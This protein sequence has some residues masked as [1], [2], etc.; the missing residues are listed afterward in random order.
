MRLK[1]ILKKTEAENVTSFIFDIFDKDVQFVWKAG[2]FLHYKIPDKSPDER[3]EARF[4]SISS[5]PF[6][7][8]IM[9]TTKFVPDDGSS[10]KKDLQKLNIEDF[11]EATGPGGDFV[12]EDSNK[13]Y[14]FIAGGIGITPFRSILLDLDHKQQPLNIT[15]LYANR[16]PDFVFKSELEQLLLKHPEFK[17]H[18][19]IEPQKINEAIIRSTINDL[20]YTIYYISGPEPMVEA[21]EK[22]LYDMGIPKDNVKRDYFPGYVGL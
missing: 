5:A 18:Y 17:I 16:T 3:G 8:N 22:M 4:F 10:F 6:E 15:L 12:V 1:L 13:Q 21:F 9:L 14:V 2:Q 20:R 19:F 11:I 7:K